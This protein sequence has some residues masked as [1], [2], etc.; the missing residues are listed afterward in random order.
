MYL[1]CYECLSFKNKTNAVPNRIIAT[2]LLLFSNFL[3]L[4]AQTGDSNAHNHSFIK[5]KVL[6]IN[7][8]ERVSPQQFVSE[9]EGI[10]QIQDIFHTSLPE[11]IQLSNPETGI[12]NT[13]LIPTSF[14]EPDFKCYTED[15]GIISEIKIN[16]GIHYQG[17]INQDNH[18]LACISLFD[19]QILGHFAL[20][21][22]IQYSLE[23]KSILNKCILTLT[24]NTTKLENYCSTND[25]DH[26]I[27]DKQLLTSRTKEN[28]K[29]TKISIRADYALY[30][31]FNKDSQLVCNYIISLFNQVNQIYRKEEIQITLSEIIINKTADGFPHTS[32]SLDLNHL[33]SKFKT[34][35]GNIHLC[36]SGY[37][38]KGKAT[39]GGVAYINALCL[40]SYA[41]AFANVEGVLNNSNTFSYDVFLASHELGHVFGSKHTHACAWGPNKNQALDN[42]AKQEGSC[43]P[44]PK[45]SI[46]SIM[47]Y[48]HLS[49]NPG[50]NFSIGFGKE[51]GDLIRGNVYASTCLTQYTPSNMVFDKPD[52][53]IIANVECFDGTYSNYY[54]DNNTI[55][56]SDD[57]LIASINKFG[58]NI[59][60]IND[61][62]LIIK[63]HTTSNYGSGKAQEFG[64][65]YSNNKIIAASRYWEINSTQALSKEVQV[66][67][68]FTSRDQKEM[69][70]LKPSLT[71]D[72]I[73]LFSTS[74]GDANPNLKHA[75]INK[76]N[77]SEFKSSTAASALTYKLSK[78]TD[79]NYSAEFQTKI[80]NDFGLITY[81]S[82]LSGSNIN[83][84]SSENN[85]IQI[86]PTVLSNREIIVNF[87]INEINN[88]FAELSL[89]TIDGQGLYQILTNPNGVQKISFDQLNLESG[90]YLVEI[91]TTK[92]NFYQKIFIK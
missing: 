89:Y 7:Q 44:A 81:G 10:A 43:S 55:D 68:F 77:F 14:I 56:E 32:A 64:T 13:E 54:F 2:A 52:L 26:Y 63:A 4:L 20:N 83:R 41:F 9:I 60:N 39:L 40:K 23:G 91:K 78:L 86:Y 90:F 88:D 74:T 6:N 85:S 15:N 92:E 18:S 51:P 3:F 34:F 31:K 48:C 65:S 80:L 11:G 49:G 82:R 19:Q 28:C 12:S 45:P 21:S 29:R 79:G 73:N 58:Q 72:Q 75:S 24:Q 27:E 8:F 17:Y 62:S 38:N 67:L 50:I 30:L 57:I 61:G 16:T 66:K 5:N 22:N 47:S 70:A 84:R 33:K 76:Y 53:N 59:G 25:W 36:L 42:C 37:T 87:G 35:N 46:G 69:Q 1:N 71:V